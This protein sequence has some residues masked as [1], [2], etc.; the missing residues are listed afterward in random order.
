MSVL[1]TSKNTLKTQYTQLIECESEDQ[2]NLVT[3]WSKLKHRF[4]DVWADNNNDN[5]SIRK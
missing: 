1:N 4:S 3:E 5:S 2:N